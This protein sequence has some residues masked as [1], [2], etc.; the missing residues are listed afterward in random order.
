MKSVTGSIMIAIPIIISLILL[1]KD[2]VG[3][4]WWAR[5][6]GGSSQDHDSYVQQTIDGGF[7]VAAHSE[8]FGESNGDIWVIKL[9]AI[10]AITWQKVYGGSNIDRANSIRQTSDGG[11]IIAAQTYSFGTGTGDIWIIKL[12]VAGTIIWQ[13]TYGST[14]PD[15]AIAA[16]ET[17]DGGY[18]VGANTVPGTGDI[19]ILKLDV[20]GTI[21]WQKKYGGSNEDRTYSMQQTSDGGYIIAAQTFS[22][23]A[24]NIDLWILKLD[25]NG[26]IIWQ[27]TYGGSEGDYIAS[28]QQTSDDGY[29]VAAQTSSFG[30][31]NGDIWIIKLDATGTIIWQKMYGGSDADWSA[32]IQQTSDGGYIV[33]GGT[34]SFG[35]VNADSLILKLDATGTITWQKV[36]GGD[37]QETV[38]S[39]EQTSDNGYITAGSILTFSDGLND[40]WVLKFDANGN[41]DPSC[42]FIRNIT[43]T[44]T[45]TKITGN[46]TSIIPSITAINSTDTTISPVNTNGIVTVMCQNAEPPGTVPDN[47]NYAGT[48]F[49]VAKSGTALVFTW[50]APGGTCI[51]QD[52]GVYRGSLPYASYDHSSIICTTGNSTTTTISSDSG[53]YYYLIV[54]QS[55]TNEGSYGLDSTNSQRP[56]ATAAC[57]PQQIGSCN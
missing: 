55:L 34:F 38:L 37:D 11:Y 19:L 32:S 40:V 25:A 26:T 50:S 53:S 29:I 3:Q 14:N 1:P 23:G 28:I 15:W 7:I 20:N 18:I 30:A 16:Q 36:Y 4:Q 10:G 41:I 2:S 46:N 44:V 9:D 52:Y 47:D 43:A 13:K 39:I 31:G 48:P 49:T 56:A 21:S 24:G 5:T 27:K 35:S 42:E 12:D 51:T 45:D 54:A 6:Y 17:S 22:F 8:S 33:A 57:L